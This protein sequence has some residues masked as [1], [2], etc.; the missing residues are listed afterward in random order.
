M[1]QKRKGVPTK[2]PA[3][4]KREEGVGMVERG[5]IFWN[6]R[7]A[8]SCVSRIINMAAKRFHSDKLLKSKYE[9]LQELDKGTTQKDLTEKYSIPKNT[10]STWKKLGQ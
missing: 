6:W 9:L 7:V 3:I 8:K 10:I 5:T 2:N 1:V 4:N